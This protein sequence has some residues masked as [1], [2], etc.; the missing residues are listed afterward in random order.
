[1]ELKE[2]IEKR[3]SIRKFTDEDIK[4]EVLIEL[5]KSAIL[6]PSGH[7]RQPWQFQIVKGKPKNELAEMLINKTK[8]VEGSTAPNTANIMKEANALIMIYLS[9]DSSVDNVMDILSIGGAIEN[10]LLSI[11]DIDLG[12]VWIG[13]IM[14]IKDEIKDI[15]GDR[16]IISC[17]AIGHKDQDPN[18]RPRKGQNE[19][20]LPMLN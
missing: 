14:H 2:V 17:I 10:I 3:R 20:I 5:I 13:N 19:V 16:E 6:A 11:T 15:V 8:D 18:P 4:E 1:M 9:E 12:G 7:N